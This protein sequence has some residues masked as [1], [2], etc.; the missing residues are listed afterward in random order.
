[1]ATTLL[2]ITVLL[3]PGR[4]FNLIV[5]NALR[6]AG[7]ARFPVMAGASSMLFVMAGGSWLL[8]VH[9]QLGLAGVWIAY[10]ADEWVRGLSM[11]ARWHWHGW[12]PYARAARRRVLQHQREMTYAEGHAEPTA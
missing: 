1:M 10:T 12:L 9:F 4:T 6:A 7:D 11:A 8:G 5:I 2:W 3:E